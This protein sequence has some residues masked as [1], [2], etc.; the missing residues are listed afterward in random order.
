MT[1]RFAV[2]I[3]LCIATAGVAVCDVSLRQVNAKPKHV[4]DPIG[5]YGIPTDNP[6]TIYRNG[7][8]L[9]FDGRARTAR[10]TLEYLTKDNLNGKADRDG[11]GFHL[12]PDAPWEFRALVSD[13]AHSGYDLGHLAAAA[14]HTSTI[15][16]MRE[17][18][19]V[20][21][22]CLQVP[23][24]NR[25]IWKN[26]EAF[27]RKCALAGNEVWVVTCPLYIPVGD[28][29]S[30]PVKTIGESRIWVPTHCA[31][32]ILVK[33]DNGDFWATGWIIPNKDCGDDSYG[34]YEVAVDDVEAAAGL[35]LFSQLP[36]DVQD[37]IER[38][39]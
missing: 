32:A 22:A 10:F 9:S 2:I 28:S 5:I 13:Y 7:F 18:F 17:T 15:E 27:V 25:G 39:K 31:K 6:T 36:K 12:E 34:K 8:V 38:G 23:A 14:N 3:G 1:N 33:P 37:K 21:N 4:V 30:I 35:D 11:I 16:A 19:T 29:K 24:F 26:L 20:N